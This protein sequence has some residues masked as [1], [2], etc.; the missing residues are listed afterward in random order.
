MIPKKVAVF[1]LVGLLAG[2][3]GPLTVLE[4]QPRPKASELLKK[5]RSTY[6]SLQSFRDRGEIE[7][8]HNVTG[9][10]ELH[11]FDLAMTSTSAGTAGGGYR[12]TLQDMDLPGSPSKVVWR[13]GS[14]VSVFDSRTGTPRTA[15]SLLSEV[16]KSYGEGGLDA[17]V[18][19]AFLAGATDV[20]SAPT[21]AAVEGPVPCDDDG[22]DR[23]WIL[24]LAREGGL[25]SRLWVDTATSLVRQAEVRMPSGAKRS[26]IRVRHEQPAVNP[27]LTAADLT[28]GGTPPALKEEEP[29]EALARSSVNPA[30][31]PR[32]DLPPSS[33]IVLEGVA[34]R[35]PA[36]P[37]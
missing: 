16:V 1:L 19:P 4:A 26:R 17:L 36:A 37:A 5:V 30:A 7:A 28:F 13:D 20:L 12:F 33:D 10:V 22:E 9:A 32:L 31:L 25:Q 2:L 8:V 15:K 14:Q 18:V 27:P 35:K 23:C 11:R 29:V 24:A 21:A 6:S 34:G 3:C